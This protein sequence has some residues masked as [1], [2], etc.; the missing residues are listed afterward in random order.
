[1]LLLAIFFISHPPPP[2]H[3]PITELALAAFWLAHWPLNALQHYNLS[4]YSYAAVIVG[5]WTIIGA[6]AGLL[7]WLVRDCKQRGYRRH[8]TLFLYGGWVLG[9]FILH[10]WVLYALAGMPSGESAK[11]DSENQTAIINSWITGYTGNLE[12]RARAR[13]AMQLHMPGRYTNAPSVEEKLAIALKFEENTE[14]YWK[15]VAETADNAKR[16]AT[17]RA[18][19]SWWIIAFTPVILLAL[20]AIKARR[21]TG[22]SQPS[23]PPVASL[24]EPHGNS[25]VGGGPPSAGRPFLTRRRI[26]IWV[27]CLLLGAGLVWGV[28]Y[29]LYNAPLLHAGGSTFSRAQDDA[30]LRYLEWCNDFTHFITPRLCA[31]YQLHPERFKP[32]GK[33]EEIEID[34]FVDYV[35]DDSYFTSGRFCRIRHGTIRDPWGDP[36]HFVQD[37]NMDGYIEARGQ[38]RNVF[39][40]AVYDDIGQREDYCNEHRLGICKDNVKGIEGHPWDS[41]FVLSYHHAKW[42]P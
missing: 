21:L 25:G 39:D 35:K 36:V 15:S 24:P 12:D 1:M 7:L 13:A 28:D 9:T 16:H 38:R 17:K 34:G 18:W 32:T 8:R 26:F 10:C 14:Y 11:R 4:V 31:Y 6:A 27:G 37:L 30:E 23:A 19:I 20:A 2:H 3:R 42:R 29:W 41:I 22:R 33:G 40:I 5:Y